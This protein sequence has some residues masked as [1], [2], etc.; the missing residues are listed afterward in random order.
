[1]L[2]YESY[3]QLRNKVE[4]PW[5][6]K[7]CILWH[8]TYGLPDAEIAQHILRCEEVALEEHDGEKG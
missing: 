1:M 3:N 6:L 4:F 5:Y 8:G 2:L 7:A